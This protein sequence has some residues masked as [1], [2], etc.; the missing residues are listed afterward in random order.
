MIHGAVNWNREAVLKLRVSEPGMS[1]REFEA[2]IDTGYDG[3]LS[4]PRTIISALRLPW[5][6]R[7]RAVLADGTEIDCEVYR[8]EIVWDGTQTPILV[9]EADTDP[10]IGM[11]LLN[12]FELKVQVRPRGKVTIKRL[13]SKKRKT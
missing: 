10:L 4:L 9:D 5:V 12:G 2:V 1:G 3:Y 8:A 6:R 13:P 7:G 11:N